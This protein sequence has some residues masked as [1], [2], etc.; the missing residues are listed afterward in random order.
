MP[1]TK[2]RYPITETPEIS[3]AL[4]IAARRWPQDRDKPRVLL[5]HLIEEGA[6][7]VETIDAE[8]VAKRREAIRRTSGSAVGIFEDGYLEKLREDWPE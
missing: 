1:T 5:L 6:R 4:A 3:R 8:R 7:A 2:P